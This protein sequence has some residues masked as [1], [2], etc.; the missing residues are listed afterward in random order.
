MKRGEAANP[1]EV[2]LLSAAALM[3]AAQSFN[4]AVVEIR[5]GQARINPI[6]ERRSVEE[7][8]M[9]LRVQLE[10]YNTPAYHT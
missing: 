10:R 7:F 1:G 9:T 6:R 2:S 4:R 8:V 5:A 3:S